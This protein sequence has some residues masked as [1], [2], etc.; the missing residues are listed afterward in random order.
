VAGSRI[1]LDVVRHTKLSE[2]ALQTRRPSAQG[3]VSAAVAGHHWAGPGQSAGRILGDLAVIHRRGR[4]LELGRAEKGER[5]AHAEA[6]DPDP[7]GAVV[8]LSESPAGA[9]DLGVRLS[10]SRSRR[11]QSRDHASDSS[12]RVQVGREREVPGGRQPIG[13]LTDVVSEPERILDHHD[14]GPRPGTP[15]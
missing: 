4:E 14:A 9:L 1:L 7:P 8:T 2:G 3:A 5:A 6:D 10:L 12:P 13:L 11:L 15:G